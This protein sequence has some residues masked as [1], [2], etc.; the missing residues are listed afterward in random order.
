MDPAPTFATAPWPPFRPVF[1]TKVTNTSNTNRIIRKKTI[2]TRLNIG[3]RTLRRAPTNCPSLGTAV[4]ATTRRRG[5]PRHCPPLPYQ[6]LL[7]LRS[8]STIRSR[9]GS[10]SLSIWDRFIKAMAATT[11]ALLLTTG[12]KLTTAA[13]TGDVIRSIKTGVFLLFGL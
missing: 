8:T 9:G 12:T 7:H 10:L 11:T 6:R 3:G 13:P 1:T 5:T 2:T 4:A